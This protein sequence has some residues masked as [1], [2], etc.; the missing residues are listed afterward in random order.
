MTEM[1]TFLGQGI[2]KLVLG[3]DVEYFHTTKLDLL[4]NVVVLNF[5]VLRS[6]VNNWID[7]QEDRSLVVQTQ[8]SRSSHIVTKF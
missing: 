3:S 5:Y 6:T 1:G 8:G 4:A 2:S 7:G